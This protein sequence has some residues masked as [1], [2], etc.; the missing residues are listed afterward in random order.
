MLLRNLSFRYKI[1]LRATVLVLVT[2]VLL[3]AVLVLRERE[4]LLR[5]LDENALMLG[6][7]LVQNLVGPVMQEDVWNVFELIRAPLAG[8]DERARERLPYAIVVFDRE[9]RVMASSDP[10]RYPVLA[11]PEALPEFGGLAPWVRAAPQM[12]SVGAVDIDTDTVGLVLPVIADGVTLGHLALAYSKDGVEARAA[13]LI[14]RS[15]FYTL[16]LLALILPITWY[17]GQRMARPLLRLSQTLREVGQRLPDDASLQIEEGGDE[18][19]R[20][21]IELRRMVFELRRKDALEREVMLNERLAAV[22]RLAAGVAHEINNPL[23]G[24]LNALDT[25]KRHGGD[26]A[27]LERT[28]SLIE[29]GLLQIRDTVSALLVEARPSG[30]PLSWHD[31]DDLHTLVA[32]EEAARD[33]QLAWE[34][35]LPEIELPLPAALVR[36]VL[37]NLLLNA[38]QAVPEGGRVALDAHLEDGLL[39]VSVVNDGTPIPPERLG[40]L[41]EP[42]TSDRPKGHGLGLWVSYQI[43]QQLD[44]H[45]GVASDD[46]GTRFTVELPL[47]FGGH[48]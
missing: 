27:K 14:E 35:R 7:T 37:L 22:G 34:V 44:G 21:G 43:V 1:P 18:L 17:W 36:Q 8:H 46:H 39:C 38:F 20:A 25:Y 32:A 26:P 10:A 3:T 40:H 13:R 9:L 45:I 15:V 31:F 33:V 12:P 42:F 28:L 6:N 5:D 4:E 41:F 48:A 19:G 47:H 29:R 24:M 16:A 11:E 23:G 2:A 30:K